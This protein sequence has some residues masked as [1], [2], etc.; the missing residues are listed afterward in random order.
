MTAVAPS[1]AKEKV[2]SLLNDFLVSISVFIEQASQ[3]MPPL[4]Q[5][6]QGCKNPKNLDNFTRNATANIRVGVFALLH[7]RIEG[8]W[9]PF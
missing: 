4:H 7:G 9:T 1:L 6:S 3:V 2:A 5:I 8:G